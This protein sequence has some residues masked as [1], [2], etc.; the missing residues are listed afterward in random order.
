VIY[1]V[2]AGPGACDLITVR[3]AELLKTADV[4]IYAGSLVNK[5]LLEMCRKDVRLYDSSRME[6]GEILEVMKEAQGRGLD[7]VRLAS[8]DPSIYGALHEMGRAL[9]DMGIDYEV[10]PGVSSFLAASSALKREYMIPEVSQS[11]VITR[12]S[13]RTEVPEREAL[14]YYAKSGCSLAVFLST[15]LLDKVARELTD[16][17][18]DEKAPVALVY[19][20]SWEDQRIIRC[21]VGD[22]AETALREGIKNT[23]LVI[24]GPVLSDE[25]RL[26]K[27]YD[28]S[29]DTLYRK[30]SDKTREETEN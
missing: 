24:A 2:G 29:F 23:A 26:S 25:R 30:A 15:S 6:L 21:T 16:G 22:M 13:G 20:V 10:C 1:F 11:L 28:A 18:F 14:S 5:K 7:T 12:V 8:G 27:L 9:E 17:G 4:V 3:G 19:R